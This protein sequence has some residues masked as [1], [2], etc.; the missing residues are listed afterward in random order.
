MNELREKILTQNIYER[1]NLIASNGSIGIAVKKRNYIKQYFPECGR[2]ENLRN[3]SL[4]LGYAITVHKAQGSGFEHVFLI[5]SKKKS[6][7]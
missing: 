1:N 6:L 2:M 4:E 3:E 5:I 7:L